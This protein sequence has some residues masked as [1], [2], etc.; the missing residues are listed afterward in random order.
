MGLVMVAPAI[1]I[2]VWVRGIRPLLGIDLRASFNWLS[3]DRLRV[4]LNQ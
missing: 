1:H 3:P 4:R 2:I